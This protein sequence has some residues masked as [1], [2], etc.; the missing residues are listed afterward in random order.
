MEA[1]QDV[2]GDVVCGVRVADPPA[3]EAAEAF[4]KAGEELVSGSGTRFYTHPQP[5]GALSSPQHSAFSVSSQQVACTAGAQQAV[6]GWC[7]AGAGAGVVSVWLSIGASLVS[8]F[9]ERDENDR[10]WMQTGPLVSSD[11]GK[12]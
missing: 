3:D 5:A 6:V 8:G 7:G 12:A 4:V 1:Q 11:T 2:L 10:E 9:N